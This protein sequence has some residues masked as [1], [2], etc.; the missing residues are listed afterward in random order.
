MTTR[1]SQLTQ[2]WT[3]Q[4]PDRA[5]RWQQ[6]ANGA[7][8]PLA[9]L[10]V[11][12]RIIVLALPGTATDDFTTVWSAARRFVERVP[13]YSETYHHVDPHYLYNPGATLLLS[14]LGVFPDMSVVRPLFILFNA[15]CIIGALAWLT[16]LVGRGLAHPVF[17]G[18]I[19]ACF[20]TEA[21]TNTLMFTNINGVLLLGLTAFLALLLHGSRGSSW[22]AGAV[23]GLCI[24]VKPMF[25]PLI[26]LPLMRLEW[27]AVVSAVAMPVLFNLVA[28]PL[29]PG[30]RDYVDIVVPYLG[31][32]R[33]YANS[34]LAGAAVYFDMPGWLHGL[35]FGII[36]AAVAVAVLGLARYRYSDEFMWAA[37]SATVLITG[38]CLLSS[39]GQA[40]YSMMVFPAVFT[41]LGRHSVFH[42]PAAWVGIFL[43]LSPLTWVTDGTYLAGRWANTFLP[44]AGWMI[45]IVAVAAWVVSEALIRREPKHDHGQ[46]DE[47]PRLDR[48]A[49]AREAQ[50]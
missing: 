23:L 11:I 6:V 14:P 31:I 32:T 44:T 49:V 36:A 4:P 24:L 17:P 28:W 9:I 43:C 40:Y 42:T 45:F 27:R 19:A 25:A 33:D 1:L 22:A 16:R 47:L 7:L 20:G 37:T 3:A 30:A 8:W 29:T 10:L 12:H 46:A 35:L 13:V 15:A 5:P 41:V 34:S 26:V 39:L 21:V 2:L 50:P 38:V 18:A 48:G